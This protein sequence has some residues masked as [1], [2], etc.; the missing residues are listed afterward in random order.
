MML[1]PSATIHPLD[2][3][4]DPSSAALVRDLAAEVAARHGGDLSQMRRANGIS[5]ATWVGGGIAVRIA[6]TPV[7][8]AREVALVRALPDAVGHPEIL[9]EGTS[10]GHGWIVTREMHGQNLYEA[11][12][13]LSAAERRE[14]I[15]QL[16]TRCQLVHGASRTL[17]AHVSSH[18]GFV[19]ATLGDA[20]ASAERAAVALG[21]SSARRSRLHDLLADYF[22]TAPL[23][24][25]VVNHGDLALMNA[26]W[27]GEVVALLDLE[28][29][30]RGPVAI[31][32]CRLVCEACVSE[33]GERVDSEAADAAV[34]IAARQLDPSHGRVLLHGAAILDQLRDLDI[35]L[36][37]D[38]AEERAAHWRPARLLIGL[39]DP[40]GGYLAPF[41]G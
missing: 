28:F 16:W 13:T 10:E 18:G 11:W 1:D 7:D 24:E 17:A 31:D 29:A 6:H 30:V 12:P 26:L 32:L 22:R 5:N 35:F 21:L 41:V 38:S 39:L 23:V 25:H 9:A 19:P 14:A 36:A 40:D 37:C 8:M 27:D 15:Q 33:E 2:Q 4:R 20:T 3:H 34:E